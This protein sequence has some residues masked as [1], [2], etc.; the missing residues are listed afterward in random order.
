MNLMPSFKRVRIVDVDGVLFRQG[1]GDK[2][3]EPELLPGS[4]ERVNEW[5]D[6]GDLVVLWTARAPIYRDLTTHQLDSFGFKYHQV[7]LG[8]PL[9]NEIHIYDDKLI[10]AH[11]LEMN[12]GLESLPTEGDVFFEHG[13]QEE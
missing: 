12:A 9:S 2:I 10:V 8:K 11:K 13:D 1:T 3:G 4:L 6:A 7:I 5:F